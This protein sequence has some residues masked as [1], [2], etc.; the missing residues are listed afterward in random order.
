MLVF[1]VPGL[2][3]KAA[4]DGCHHYLGHQDRDCTLSLLRE[5]FWWPGM[6]QRMMINVHN[7][8]KCRIFEA[9]PQISLM[10]SII[11]TEL[12]NLVHIDYMSMEVT[13]GSCEECIGCRRPLYVLHS[14]ICHEQPHGTH[15]GVRA[16]WVSTMTHV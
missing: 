2:K 15:H 12:L 3:H 5:R 11:C 9:K 4:I 1:V 10:E 7:C 13:M 16:V 6:A 14:R 8:K